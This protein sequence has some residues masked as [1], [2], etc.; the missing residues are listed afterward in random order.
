MF[1]AFLTLSP[2]RSSLFALF[3]GLLVAML[4]YILLAAG[5]SSASKPTKLRRL[6]VVAT[7]LPLSLFIALLLYV[8]SLLVTAT[9]IFL[10]LIL[11]YAI[12][13]N[14]FLES[15]KREVAT[16][17]CY[18]AVGLYSVGIGIFFWT[19]FDTVYETFPSLSIPRDCCGIT[20]TPTLPAGIALIPW[21]MIL[22]GS[23]T[24]LFTTLGKSGVKPL[25]SLS[26]GLLLAS[27][28]PDVFFGF[29]DW[30]GMPL[31]WWGHTFT[32]CVGC[33]GP[34]IGYAILWPFLA[35]WAAWSIVAVILV[36]PIRGRLIIQSLTKPVEA[37]FRE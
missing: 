1:A 27:T 5:R 34:P 37:P 35:N 13:S 11:I 6:L 36:E 29:G 22:I 3:Y 12:S 21:L 25:A 26:L 20:P 24:I 33:T 8:D 10:G 32:S 9:P 18:V 23:L 31:A 16:R 14:R 28:L 17:L 2:L 19:N 7:I 4:A 30:T 15:A